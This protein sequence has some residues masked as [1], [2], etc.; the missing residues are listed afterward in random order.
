MCVPGTAKSSSRTPEKEGKEWQETNHKAAGIGH[1]S[2][3]CNL[4]MEGFKQGSNVI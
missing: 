2:M 1:R 4:N 3:D